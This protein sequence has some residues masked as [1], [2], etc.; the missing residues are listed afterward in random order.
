MGYIQIAL[1]FPLKGEKLEEILLTSASKLKLK[2]RSFEETS[3]F[4]DAKEGKLKSRYRGNSIIIGKNSFPLIKISSFKKGAQNS[5]FDISY[6]L[7]DGL[8]GSQK[9]AERYLQEFQNNL[10]NDL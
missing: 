10:Y 9:I 1:D 5:W 4:Y 7:I 6:G 8:F 3:K 2:A